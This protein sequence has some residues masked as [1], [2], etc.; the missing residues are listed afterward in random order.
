M[1]EISRMALFGKLNRVAYKAIEGATVFCKLRGNPYVELEHWVM[2]IVQ[3]QDSDWH[4]I[5]KHYQV[6]MAVLA[7]DITTA[8]DRLPRGSTSITDLSSH[9]EE[10]VERGWV[11]GSLMFGEHQ[12]RTG[13]LIIGILKTP[14]L[15]QVLLGLSGEFAKIKVET[16]SERFDEYVRTLLPA[17][18]GSKGA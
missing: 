16:L 3:A 2:Q 14:S 9:V 15:R 7:R 5:I 12:V 8:L 6:D 11:Y 10:A 17:A 1:S 13:Y 4:R 18:T